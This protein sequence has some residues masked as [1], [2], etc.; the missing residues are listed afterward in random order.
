MSNISRRDFLKTAGVMTLAVAAAGVLA[1]CEGNVAEPE[2]PIEMTDTAVTIG[3]YTLSIKAAKQFSI[4]TT[5]NNQNTNETRYVVVVGNL[6]KID[7]QKNSTI[8]FEWEDDSANMTA[9]ADTTNVG[10]VGVKELFDLP[11]APKLVKNVDTANFENET[12]AGTPFYYAY[13]VG[14]Y[15]D[16]SFKKPEFKLVVTEEK[17]QIVKLTASIP[18]AVTVKADDL[19]KNA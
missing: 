12:S 6:L 17:E 8:G 7:E 1:G 5:D 9:E 10:A 14:A 16:G 3:N 13:E 11:V 18:A 4:S 19:K 15:A 2:K